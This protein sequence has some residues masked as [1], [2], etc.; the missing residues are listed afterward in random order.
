LA[1][2]LGRPLWVQAVVVLWAKTERPVTETHN[3]TY[4]R[5]ENL[6]EWLVQRPPRLSSEDVHAIARHVGG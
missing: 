4:V 3:V 1:T 6:T 5:G 2:A